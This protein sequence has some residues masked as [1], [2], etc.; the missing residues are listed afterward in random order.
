MLPRLLRTECEAAYTFRVSKIRITW[1]VIYKPSNS[2]AE[3]YLNIGWE[4][5]P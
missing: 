3:S 1:L 5:L 4:V 2:K